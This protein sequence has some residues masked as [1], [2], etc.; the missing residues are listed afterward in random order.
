MAEYA[1]VQKPHLSSNKGQLKLQAEKLL[2]EKDSLECQGTEVTTAVVNLER[3]RRN[4][5]QYSVRDG[6]KRCE[7]LDNA[8][9]QFRVSGELYYDYPT[10]H[11]DAEF[12][13]GTGTG[14]VIGS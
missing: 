4:P 6:Q 12:R 7:A 11:R 9:A 2:Q 8:L 5:E 1:P 13:T 10:Y 14:T 3:W